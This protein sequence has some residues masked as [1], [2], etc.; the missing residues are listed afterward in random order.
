MKINSLFSFFGLFL[1]L[2]SCNDSIAD[3]TLVGDDGQK[4]SCTQ[5]ERDIL[6]NVLTQKNGYYRYGR[7][8]SRAESDFKISPYI[9]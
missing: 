8:V 2:V 9:Y 7:P 3:I 6:A 5:I 1:V 4:S